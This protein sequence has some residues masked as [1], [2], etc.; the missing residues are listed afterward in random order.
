MTP[1]EHFDS[2]ELVTGATYRYVPQ[3][4]EVTDEAVERAFQAGA[5]W[6]ADH[7]DGASADDE[8]RDFYRTVLEAADLRS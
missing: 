3:P 2:G 6:F 1:S 8:W 7:P 4:A 5:R